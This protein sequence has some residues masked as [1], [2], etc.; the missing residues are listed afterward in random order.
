MSF[1]PSR[2]ETIKTLFHGNRFIIP[3]YQRKYSWK[4]DQRK[5]LWDD[6][7]E[8]LTMKHFIGTLCFKKV[9]NSTDVFSD[10]YEIIDG[11]QRTTTLFILLNVL[12]EK[13]TS[14]ELKNGFINLYIG[15]KETP[16]LASL[17][18]DQDFLNN[19]IFDFT[20]I[21]EDKLIV[22]SQINLYEAKK[23]FIGLCSKFSQK[24]IV[25]WITFISTN[26]EILIFN[27][28]HQAEAVKMFS[29][30]NDRGLPLS[31]LDKTKSLLML[32]STLYLNEEINEEINT[33]FGDIF[34]SFDEMVFL[35]NKLSLFRTL[36][37]YDFENTFYTH[38]YYT[39]KWLFP[40]WDYQLGADNIFKQLKKLCEESKTNVVDLRWNIEEYVRDFHGFALAYVAL[41]RKVDQDKNYQKYFLYMEFAAT[42]YPLLVRLHEQKKLDGLL[43]IIEVV[44][45][46]VYKL[47]NTNPRRNMYFLSSNIIEEEWTIE[48]IETELTN[49]VN[50]FCNDYFTEQYLLD[51]VD[52]KTSLVRY[53]LYKQNLE[54]HGQDLTLDEFRNLQVEHI[55]SVSPN[56]AIKQYGFGKHETYNLEIAKIGNLTI[57]EKAI[58]KDV[59]NM[60][61]TDKLSGYQKSK[62]NLNSNLMG[63]LNKF[64]KEEIANRTNEIIEFFM[65]EF[66]I[67][68][69]TTS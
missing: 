53:T 21:M 29:V 23:D 6:I 47:K 68:E 8:N 57:L 64:N 58:N 62:I 32:Y 41:L 15:S 14:D 50:N 11:Q 5:A 19:V 63:N 45:M 25:D 13:I 22:R 18:V 37:D 44:E 49:F 42:L 69:E 24:D 31:N 59:N 60:A 36:D 55:F 4:F 51:Q 61:P 52:N 17:G 10:V 66:Y 20:S 9:E 40:D 2:T 28:T 48:E 56:F 12:I 35:K 26:I 43:R 30:I 65:S 38:Y 34:D 54:T 16:K 67:T 39:A 33:K 27:V 7:G 1:Q 46:R 3:A